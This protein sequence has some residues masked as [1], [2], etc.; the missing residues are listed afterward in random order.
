MRGVPLARSPSR[1][2]WSSSVWVVRLVTRRA[3]TGAV[4]E[5]LR[6]ALGAGT[7]GGETDLRPLANRQD[8]V[9]ADEDGHFA[10]AQCIVALCGRDPTGRV[11]HRG[12]RGDAF[13]DLGAAGPLA[14]W[15][16]AVVPGLRAAGLS[17]RCPTLR[18]A[19]TIR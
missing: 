15:A 11:Q 17:L 13:R 10:D 7:H 2:R 19:P 1:R 4:A 18:L 16:A 9:A 3:M 12:P 6:F 8:V 5:Q 14:G